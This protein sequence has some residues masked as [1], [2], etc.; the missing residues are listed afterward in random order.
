MA[1]GLSLSTLGNLGRVASRG[2]EQHAQRRQENADQELTRDLLTASV[3]G[4]MEDLRSK[5]E[6]GY[7]GKARPELLSTAGKTVSQMMQI[8]R[9]EQREKASDI[10]TMAGQ[11]ME[12]GTMTWP[13]AMEFAR[14]DHKNL[15]TPGYTPKA[16][17]GKNLIE[18]KFKG[19]SGLRGEELEETK[20]K[21]TTAIREAHQQGD[22][23]PDEYEKY[24]Q[25]LQGRDQGFGY[26]VG[27][28]A[29]GVGKFIESGPLSLKGILE[30]LEGFGKGIMQSE[31]VAPPRRGGR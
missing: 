23:G 9:T 21:L 15:M 27:Q 12:T 2:V 17:T 20:A 19:L 16:F 6:Q 1:L 7:Y 25:L 29:R 10:R 4:D 8:Q 5:L 11:Y 13:E 31:P 26:G 28:A 14:E 3:K 18:Q 24:M 22:I 30:G